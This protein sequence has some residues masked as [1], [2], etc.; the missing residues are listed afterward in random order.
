M[1]QHVCSR[2]SSLCLSLSLSAVFV[3]VPSYPR[4]SSVRCLMH[5][6]KN[7]R[8]REREGGREGER[9]RE[10]TQ[11]FITQGLRF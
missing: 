5:F 7:K 4:A 10:R 8:E 11:N 3:K 9:E 2:T 1:G 6:E